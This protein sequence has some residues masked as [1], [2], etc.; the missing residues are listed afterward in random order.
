MCT[1]LQNR[2]GVTIGS[3]KKQRVAGG[4]EVIKVKVTKGCKHAG[5]T[6]SPPV[7][8]V[9]HTEGYDWACGVI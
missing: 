3:R 5:T 4:W 7:C 8:V 2:R 9:K 1:C 6:E